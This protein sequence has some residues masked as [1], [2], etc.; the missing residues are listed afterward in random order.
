[1][2]SLLIASDHAGFDLKEK[3]KA[4]ASA[5]G[6]NFTDLGPSSTESVDYPDYANKLCEA[7]IQKNKG[8]STESQHLG[9]LICGSGVGVSIAANRFP[10]IRAVLAESPTVA[11]LSRE[12]NHANVLC[13]GA[14]IVSEATALEMIRTFLDTKPDLGPRHL[15]R[16][17]KLQEQA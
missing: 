4:N 7:L 12:H 1:M 6:V 9:I 3:L 16:I 17:K 2:T 10:E 8:L 5:L 15:N 14:R 13:M 11:K